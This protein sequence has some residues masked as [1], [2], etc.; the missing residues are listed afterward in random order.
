MVIRQRLLQFPF[1]TASLNHSERIHDSAVVAEITR[2]EG[3]FLRSRV[4]LVAGELAKGNG[5][6]T[7]KE[8]SGPLKV[9][10]GGQRTVGSKQ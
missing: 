6:M 8:A 10:G 3:V 4:S 9:E 2:I 7:R 1:L 5:E